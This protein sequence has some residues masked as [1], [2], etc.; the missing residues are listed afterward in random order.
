MSGSPTILLSTDLIEA[1]QS[2]FAPEEGA[3]V[4][5]LGVVR[6]DEA[7]KTLR[8]IDYTAYHSMASRTLADL[9]DEGQRE[10]GAHRVF[11]QH[12]L[13]FV[14]VGD[15]SIAIYVLTKHSGAAFDL[16]RWYLQR[17][18]QTVPIWKNPVTV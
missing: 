16:C 4:R 18:K 17:I 7:G 13:G 8:G 3:E 2:V 11:I 1:R 12:R 6:A 14:P 10:H 9:I 5:F 15:A